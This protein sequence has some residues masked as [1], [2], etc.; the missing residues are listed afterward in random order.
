[1]DQRCCYEVNSVSAWRHV[2]NLPKSNVESLAS[3]MVMVFDCIIPQECFGS[4]QLNWDTFLPTQSVRLFTL[5]MIEYSTEWHCWHP[6][7]EERNNTYQNGRF[8]FLGTSICE[9][10]RSHH[11]GVDAPESAHFG[12]TAQPYS[13]EA[14]AWL[15]REIEGNNLW[16]QIIRRDQYNRIVSLLWCRATAI[17]WIRLFFIKVGIPV[18]PPCLPFVHPPAFRC[19]SISMLSAGYAQTYEQSGA[20]YGVWGKD[21]FLRHE[22]AARNVSFCLCSYLQSCADP[23]CLGLQNVACGLPQFLWS[24]QQ[25]TRNDIETQQRLSQT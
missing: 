25:S 11:I 5:I 20:E 21:T 15:K 2:L 1:M 8:V 6:R 23:F 17:N 19:V 13:A 10:R 4:G 9:H 16:V 18:H 12:K 24:P 3:V 14:L 22:L 7:I